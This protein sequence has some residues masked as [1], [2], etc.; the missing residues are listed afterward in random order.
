MEKSLSFAQMRKIIEETAKISNSAEYLPT[1]FHP[2]F[3]VLIALE[4]FALL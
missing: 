1:S 3:P 2:V 4:F